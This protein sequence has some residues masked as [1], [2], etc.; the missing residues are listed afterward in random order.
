MITGD[1]RS[2]ALYGIVKRLAPGRHPRLMV[3]E[4]RFDD[5]RPTLRWHLK[6]IV[7]RF[8]FGA[9]DVVCVSARREATDYAARLRLGPERFKFVPWHTNVID[10]GR[11]EEHCG[12]VFAAG[13]TGRDWETLARAASGLPLDFVGVMSASAA[14]RTEFPENF[15]VHVDIPYEHYREL[16]K[17]A[18]LVVIPLDVHAYSSGQVALLEAMALG[19]PVICTKVLGT[20]DYLQ[21]SFNGI[22]VS[23]NDP[24]ELAAAISHVLSAPSVEHDLGHQAVETVRREHTFERYVTRILECAERLSKDIGSG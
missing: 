2:A 3:L 12:Y 1:V 11:R 14:S 6:G 9:V 13:R 21:H 23:P 8:A 7:Q 16:L 19:K 22:F 20:E 24:H 18:R 4:A 10:P 17:N 15:S 5:P